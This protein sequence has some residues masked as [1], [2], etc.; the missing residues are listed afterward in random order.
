MSSRHQ[1]KAG[2]LNVKQDLEY[3]EFLIAFDLF[4]QS[5]QELRE[6]I[7]QAVEEQEGKKDA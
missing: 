4:M 2:L 5:I 3:I 6:T 1:I 7:Q